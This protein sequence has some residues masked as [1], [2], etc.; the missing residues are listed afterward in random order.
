MFGTI[1]SFGRRF[2]TIVEF[3]AIFAYS[4]DEN[5]HAEVIRPAVRDETGPSRLVVKTRRTKL[6]CLDS[7]S[8]STRGG[9]T[10]NVLCLYLVEQDIQ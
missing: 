2:L 1:R 7:R 10:H 6:A 5:V 8:S 3:L 9:Q 4:C